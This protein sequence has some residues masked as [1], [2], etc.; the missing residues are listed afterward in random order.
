[1]GVNRIRELVESLDAR[2]AQSPYLD[3][4]RSR[5]PSAGS[6]RRGAGLDALR[7]EILA[8]MAASLGRAEDHV[9]EALLACDLLDRE[10]ADLVARGATASELAPKL[11]AFNAEVDRAER[12][13]WELSVQREAIGIRR[14]DMLA[15]HYPIPKRK[16]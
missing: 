5:A 11:A 4:L 1:M 10:I 9:N 8:E 6:R 2:G 12:R 3:R 7:A 16:R 13:L 14:N 15:D